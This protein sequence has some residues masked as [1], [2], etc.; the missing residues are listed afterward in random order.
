MNADPPAIDTSKFTASQAARAAYPNGFYEIH[1][2]CDLATAEG[3][4]VK[5]HYLR[6]R[7]GELPK[8]TGISSPYEIPERPDLRVNTATHSVL[9]SAG[10][11]LEFIEEHVM[12]R[13]GVSR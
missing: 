2:E 13:A 9:E 10:T 8:F 3:R 11:L 5:G 4:D 1:V 12:Q 7:N 6:A